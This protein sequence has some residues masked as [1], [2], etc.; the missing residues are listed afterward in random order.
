VEESRLR[1]AADEGRLQETVAK[2]QLRQEALVSDSP[3]GR[4][5]TPAASAKSRL[6]SG[7]RSHEKLASDIFKRKLEEARVELASHKKPLFVEVF[8]ETTA[9]MATIVDDALQL[10]D[11][12]TT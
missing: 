7:S 3:R 8:L 1:L 2:E 11:G 12:A 4:A 6:R 5:N 9:V 10:S